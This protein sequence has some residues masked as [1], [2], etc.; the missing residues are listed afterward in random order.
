MA[1]KLT[2]EQKRIWKKYS[3]KYSRGS[4]GSKIQLGKMYLYNYAAETV[5]F[6]DQYP[7]PI[8]I[9][10]YSDGWLGLN[11][12]YLPPKIREFFIKKVIIKNYKFLKKGLPAQ[13]SY[14]DIKD[15]GNLWY[16]EGIAIIKRY[17][18]SRV[19]SNL[20]EIPW[21]EW[22]NIS[23]G[24]GAQWMNATAE[25]VYKETKQMLRS[26]Y[27]KSSIAAKNKPTKKSKVPN[28]IT[29]EKERTLKNKP[30]LRRKR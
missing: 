29:R 23:T 28:Y 6:W 7:L 22:L 11:I 15:V 3:Q 27:I 26:A 16:K 13:I 9:K 10:K 14:D 2:D 4:S 5:P 24:E 21:T 25:A 19:K 30:K 18:S 20:V 8:I 12:H 1:F 17:K